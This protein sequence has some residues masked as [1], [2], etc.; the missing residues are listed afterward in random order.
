MVGAAQQD[1]EAV[2]QRFLGEIFLGDGG[3]LLKPVRGRKG[4]K[5]GAQFSVHLVPT[6]LYFFRGRRVRGGFVRARKERIIELGMELGAQAEQR[7][8]SVM[9]CGEMSPEV[10]QAIFARSDFFCQL[11]RSEAGKQL[12]G[13]VNGC[14]P[15]I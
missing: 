2:A 15:K 11:I 14:V 13:P 8:H 12:V 5:A 3:V 1:C 10:D 6:F 7:E 9:N 4:C